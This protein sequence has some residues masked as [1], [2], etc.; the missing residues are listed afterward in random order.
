MEQ[1]TADDLE[2]AK[3]ERA[4]HEHDP[5]AGISRGK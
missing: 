5:E 1:K 3:I 4:D 2:R